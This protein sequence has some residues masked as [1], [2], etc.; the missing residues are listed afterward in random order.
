MAGD[1]HDDDGD[2]HDDDSCGA[3]WVVMSMMT[4]VGHGGW[5]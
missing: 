2:E 4:V 1:E 3:W 5:R